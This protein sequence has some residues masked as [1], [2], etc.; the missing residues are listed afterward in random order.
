M[1]QMKKLQ[2]Q[3]KAVAKELGK[4]S[5]QVEKVAAQVAKQAEAKPTPKK[6][7]V[8]KAAP[9]KARK[10]TPK[11]KAAPA[12]VAS[13]AAA[14]K[15]TVLDAVYEIVRRARSGAT[16]AVLKE[17]TGLN[18]RQLSNALYK[19]STRGKIAAKSRGVY[20]KK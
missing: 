13:A 4:L 18:P 3:L 5:K 20:V 16:I 2:V 14:K 7:A 12:K 10:A 15:P 9:P 19:L 8:K 1:D 11:K 17:K 6:K